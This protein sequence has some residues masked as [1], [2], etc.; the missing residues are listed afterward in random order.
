[1]LLPLSPCLV[2][3]RQQPSAHH[4]QRQFEAYFATRRGN[5]KEL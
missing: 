1:V 5:L 3:G 2:S 4:D